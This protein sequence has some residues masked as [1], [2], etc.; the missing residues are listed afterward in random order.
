MIEN[1]FKKLTIP[2]S[3][4]YNTYRKLTHQEENNP[5]N[6]YDNR[7]YFSLRYKHYKYNTTVTDEIYDNNR[8]KA[9]LKL[10]VNFYLLSIL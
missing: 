9:L 10:D 3:S 1:D 6:K 5:K 4:E 8:L 2:K 7:L